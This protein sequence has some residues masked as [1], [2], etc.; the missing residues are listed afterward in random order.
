METVPE[1]IELIYS[2]VTDDSRWSS[3]LEAIVRA[4]R[5]Q[6]AALALRD[7]DREEFPHVCWHGWSDQD[8]Q[9]Y[10]ERFAAI[11]PLRIG[12]AR[13][14]E[15]VV[16][17]DTDACPR[18]ELEASGA[19]REFYVSRDCIHGMAGTILVTDAG[20]SFISLIRGAEE[21]P[22]GDPEKAI[23]QALMPHLKQA[24]L[25]HGE[26]GSLRR[27]LATFTAHLD[28][29]PDALLL[30]DTECRVLYANVAAQEIAESE[31]GLVVRAGRLSMTS[32]KTDSNFRAVLGNVIASRKEAMQAACHAGA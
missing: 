15:G 22:F 24:A 30:T 6:R 25:L 2:A 17:F 3:V 20:Q 16:G 21:G 31:D 8:I 27:R 7:L 5:S 19:F 10:F 4:T 23:L 28:R 9:L 12:A 11:D 1:L 32:S 26:F 18:Q 13:T 14:P 29:S